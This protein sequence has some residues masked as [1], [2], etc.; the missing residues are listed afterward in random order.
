MRKSIILSGSLVV[1]AASVVP[2]HAVGGSANFGVTRVAYVSETHGGGGLLG[3]TCKYARYAAGVGGSGI[4]YEIVG[5]GHAV[6][7]Y[8]GIPVVATGVRCRFFHNGLVYNSGPE[9]LPGPLA[10][11]DRQVF[12][13]DASGGAA[14]VTVY[15][16]LR[17]NPPGE[18]DNVINT[19]EQC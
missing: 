14:C 8:N 10:E 3:G 13:N 17:Q 11:T 9:Y 1:A 5:E 6:G 18:P 16:V 12:S 4:T 2:A 7:S 19:T 15:A